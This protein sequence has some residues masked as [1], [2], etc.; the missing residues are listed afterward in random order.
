[1]DDLKDCPFCGGLA[2]MSSRYD[3]DDNRPDG[4]QFFVTCADC[5][6]Q[7]PE[8]YAV[9]TNEIHLNQKQRIEQRKNIEEA[10]ENAWKA[11]NRRR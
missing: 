10:Q 4:E 6:A 11:W 2:E 9:T 5:G 8:F 1:M 3:S 7:G